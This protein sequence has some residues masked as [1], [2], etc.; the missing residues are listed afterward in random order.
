MKTGNIRAEFRRKKNVAKRVVKDNKRTWDERF[1]RILSENFRRD[2]KLFW[3][4]VK[5][6]IGK[7]VNNS[8]GRVKNENGQLLTDE[9]DIKARWKSYFEGLLNQRDDAKTRIDVVGNLRVNRDEGENAGIIREDEVRIA[10]NK[11]KDGM[12]A[13]SD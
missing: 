4:E 12:A 7:T 10:L 8:T 3:K 5:N 2:K 6:V 1:G 9:R 11:V 13:G